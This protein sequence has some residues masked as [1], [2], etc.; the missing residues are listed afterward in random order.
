MRGL[1]VGLPVEG[2]YAPISGGPKRRVPSREASE[3]RPRTGLPVSCSAGEPAKAH[4]GS[5]AMSQ[6][7]LEIVER[8]IDHLNET[9]ELPWAEIDPE[10]V[11]DPPPDTR[12]RRLCPWRGPR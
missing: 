8:C 2:A 4:L 7:N 6:E 11:R 1:P 5:A 10:V 12:P 3:R 9:G